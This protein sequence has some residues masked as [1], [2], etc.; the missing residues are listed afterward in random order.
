MIFNAI[1]L[2]GLNKKIHILVYR[3]TINIFL[4]KHLF[5]Y[6]YTTQIIAI[7]REKFT[8]N[9]T[10]AYFKGLSIIRDVFIRIVRV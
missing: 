2:V 3:A 7:A 4:Y 1:H 10:S 9:E 6:M 8:A 5:C